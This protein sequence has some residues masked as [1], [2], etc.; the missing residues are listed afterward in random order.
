MKPT[1]RRA[2]HL[3]QFLAL[4]AVVLLVAACGEKTT[5][6]A[7]QTVTTA[8]A[9]TTTAAQTTTTRAATTSTE[10]S[11]TTTQAVA[12]PPT[13]STPPDTLAKPPESV[14]VIGNSTVMMC[15]GLAENL[16][17]LAASLDPPR[18]IETEAVYQAGEHLKTLYCQGS[19]RESESARARIKAGGHDA[20]VLQ[21]DPPL[22]SELEFPDSFYE[23]GRLFDQ[24]IRAA[25]GQ[26]VLFMQW[27]YPLAITDFLPTLDLIAQTHRDLGSELRAPVAPVG[28]A[29]AQSQKE[30]PELVLFADT[31]VHANAAGAYLAACVL[32][33]TLFSESPEG[34]TWA[35]EGVSKKDAAFLQSVAWETVQDWQQQ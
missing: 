21:E 32:Y 31:G 14:L 23:Y 3:V 15:D 16:N 27:T 12:A 33:A 11:T 34:A 2:A 9:V 18:L 28:L 20:V 30:R 19:A 5:T 29:F 6:T 24:E 4:F 8:A 1:R 22:Y 13:A 26:T 17:R 7:T 35:V 25:G 10:A